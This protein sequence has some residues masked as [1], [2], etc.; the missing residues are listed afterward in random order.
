M[1]FF[2]KHSNQEVDALNLALANL[3]ERCSLLDE[4]SGIGLWEAYMPKGDATH[5]DAKWTWSGEFRRLMGFSNDVEFPNVM[6][7]WSD[8]LHPDDVARTFEAF[9][10]HLKDKTGGTRYKVEYR[11]KMRDGNYRWFRA[12]G[13]CQYQPDGETVR[14][15][16]SLNDIHEERI[17]QER[18]AENEA[19]SRQAIAVLSRGLSALAQNDL[20]V[21]LDEAL[22]SDFD[23][24][25]LDFNSSVAQLNET[26][27]SVAGSVVSI[28]NGS[29]EISTGADDLSRRTEQQAGALAHTAAALVQLS[30]NVTTSSKRS[31]EARQVSV[32]ANLAASKSVEVVEQAVDAMS[33]IETSARQIANIIGVIDEIAFQTNLLALNAGVEAARVGDAG[34]GFAVVAQEVRELAQRSA[35]A[36]KEIKELI[37]ASAAEV[38]AGV[39]LVSDTGTSLK[40]IGD[41]IVDINGHMEAIA[42]SSLEQSTGLSEVSAAVN[43]IDQTTQ[44]NASMGE[45]SSAAAVSLADEANNLRKLIEQFDLGNTSVKALRGTAQAMGSSRWNENSHGRRTA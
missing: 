39:K 11:L 26:L 37:Q 16:G 43:Q 12:T 6:E 13:G 44:Q 31:Q 34:K 19:Q 41:F 1:A 40:A 8:R 2:T 45:Q 29:H 30:S 18:A 17:L 9:G 10:N 15:C 4:A 23:Q 24:L 7:S 25:R 21:R 20:H 3:K 33:R 36:A 22:S 27:S 5:K 42:T 32:Q 28:S 35:R 14:A 38:S